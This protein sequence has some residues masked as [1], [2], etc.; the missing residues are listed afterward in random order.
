MNLAQL[1][2]T[3]GARVK[4][5]PRACRLNNLGIPLPEE[6]IE[7]LVN[8]V[9]NDVVTL[10][11]IGAGGHFLKLG[12]DHIHHFTTDAKRSIGDL[13]CGFLTLHVQPFIQGMDTWVR[14]N[15]RP[16]EAVAP[17]SVQI[18]DKA[19]DFNYPTDSGI[20][21][22]LQQQGYKI[23]WVLESRLARIIELEAYELVIEKRGD[24]TLVRFRVRDPRDDQVLVKK[25]VP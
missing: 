12:T 14:P 19:V 11:R 25:M 3:V 17:P 4:L 24:G 23:S 8:D 21:A 15:S 16:G 1:K 20:Q 22:R 9:T 2:K 7:W 18:E 6:D 13:R 5:E 10:N